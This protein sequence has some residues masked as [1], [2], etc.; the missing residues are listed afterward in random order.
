MSQITPPGPR[1][2]HLAGALARTHRGLEYKTQSQTGS[3]ANQ[4]ST[5]PQESA[6]TPPEARGQL[7]DTARRGTLSKNQ[8]Y[9]LNLAKVEAKRLP[10][11]I[12]RFSDSL[13]ALR[14]SLMRKAK[15]SPP[16]RGP[17]AEALSPRPSR[18]GPA[19]KGLGRDANSPIRSRLGS[20]NNLVTSVPTEL[21]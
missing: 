9:C 10:Q 2:L 20:A 5:K 16:R 15:S 3:I 14:R 18:R 17:L 8:K 1:G 21:L 13:E 4:V 19:P 12:S 6:L 11:G 7:S